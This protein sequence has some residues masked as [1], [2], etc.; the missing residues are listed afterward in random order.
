LLSAF[1]HA[2]ETRWPVFVEQAG[3]IGFRWGLWLFAGKDSVVDGLDPSRSHEGPQLHFSEE[4]GG[5]LMLDR[6]SA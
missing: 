4:V 6:S 5:V 1:F 2:D 3:K